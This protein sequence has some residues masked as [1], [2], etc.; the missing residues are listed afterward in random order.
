MKNHH[1]RLPNPVKYSLWLLGYKGR[2]VKDMTMALK[3]RGFEE[4]V[5][6]DTI[7]TLLDWGYLNDSQF[8]EELIERRKRNNVKG[9]AF[10]RRELEQSGICDLDDLDDLY[11]DEEEQQIISELLEKWGRSAPLNQDNR[12]KYFMRLANRGFSRSNIFAA[13]EKHCDDTERLS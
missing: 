3:K 12:G 8:K 10:V 1:G 7:D 5:I 9:R 11:S 13:I 4:S 2:S 6:T